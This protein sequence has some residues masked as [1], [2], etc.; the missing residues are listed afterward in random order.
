MKSNF[1]LWRAQRTVLGQKTK[2]HEWQ[3]HNKQNIKGQKVV[4]RATLPNLE[5]IYSVNKNWFY[6]ENY[7]HVRFCLTTTKNILWKLRAAVNR[8]EKLKLKGLCPLA[9]YFSLAMAVHL[10]QRKDCKTIFFFSKREA[11]NVLHFDGA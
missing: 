8:C 1:K 7:W 6:E 2:P 10:S 4:L 3:T 11:K 5:H 9:W